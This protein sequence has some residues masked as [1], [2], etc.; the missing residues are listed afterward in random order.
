LH[1]IK[2]ISIGKESKDDYHNIVESYKKM[3]SGFSKI[4]NKEIFNKKIAASQKQGEKSAKSSYTDELTKHLGSYNIILHERGKQLDSYEFS[5]IF[6]RE[7]SINFF[8]G[9][10]YGFDEEFLKKGNM[11]LSLS[12]MTTSH[13]IAKIMLFEQIYRALSIVNKHPY[14]K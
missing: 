1:N 12:K 11:L 6:E 7:Y 4:E 8:I 13:K 5:S 14:H 3:I 2:V 9:G 10:A